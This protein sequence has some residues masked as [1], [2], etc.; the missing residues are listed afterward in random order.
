MARC[1]CGKIYQRLEKSKG[2]VPN[3][4]HRHLN[5]TNMPCFFVKKRRRHH[6]PCQ[7]RL[8]KYSGVVAAPSRAD[9]Y[10]GKSVSV[11][12][13]KY[14]AF[15]TAVG[16]HK[17]SQVYLALVWVKPDVCLFCTQNLC[18]SSKKA[19]WSWE[20]NDPKTH[21]EVIRTSTLYVSKQ[22][23]GRIIPYA[24]LKD[25]CRPLV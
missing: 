21:T 15:R 1:S 14:N 9:V 5:A 7:A 10:I 25:R 17:P 23:M 18:R 3:K 4:Q 20:K 13:L 11:V 12:N 6:F 22:L 19:R 16:T 2:R 8:L 24:H